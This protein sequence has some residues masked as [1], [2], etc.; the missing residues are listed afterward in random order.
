[1]YFSTLGSKQLLL[2]KVEEVV[3]NTEAKIQK[4]QRTVAGNKIA[5]TLPAEKEIISIDRKLVYKVGFN[6][7]KKNYIDSR[8]C[9]SLSQYEL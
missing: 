4:Y 7:T 2:A 6:L 5:Y 9:N 8:L 1:M 3:S